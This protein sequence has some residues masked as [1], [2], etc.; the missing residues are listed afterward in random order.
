LINI[1]AIKMKNQNI[2]IFVLFFL[3]FACKNYFEYHLGAIIRGDKNR[4]ELAL[5]FTG[6]EFADGADHIRA[7]LSSF[8]IKAA[9]FL[10]GNFYRNPNFTKII[11]ALREDGH[12]LGAH[13]DKHL[14]YCSWNNRDSLLVS[15]EKFLADLDSNYAAMRNF[16][17]QKS[18]ARFFLPPYEWYNATIARWCQE[19]GIKLVNFTPGTKSHTDWTHP[20]IGK[21]YVSSEDIYKSILEF[22]KKEK[23]GL[24]GLILLLHIGSDPRR[25]DKFH[26]K[27]ADL[28]DYL[29]IRGYQFKR[30]DELLTNE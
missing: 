19:I 27:L 6:D 4:N 3:V 29:M 23:Y 18:D 14:L 16:G 8:N 17:I 15:K 30:I 28:I 11:S 1:G 12:Y 22:E 7:V 2:K 5:V 24:N 9:F 20:A 25:A 13:S 10:T 26:T 21:G